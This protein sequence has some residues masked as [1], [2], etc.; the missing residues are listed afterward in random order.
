MVCGHSKLFA[1]SI[2]GK[3]CA[4]P[5]LPAALVDNSIFAPVIFQAVGNSSGGYALERIR[6][7]PANLL[8]YLV[9]EPRDLSEILPGHRLLHLFP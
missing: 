2:R 8:R 1:D 7:R 5:P 6:E 9:I 4:S 3:R